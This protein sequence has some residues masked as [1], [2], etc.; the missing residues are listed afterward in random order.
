MHNYIKLCECSISSL[1]AIPF[2]FTRQAID[3]AILSFQCNG[4]ELQP[5]IVYLDT[6]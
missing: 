1:K 4:G 2:D 6:Q 5:V 3:T